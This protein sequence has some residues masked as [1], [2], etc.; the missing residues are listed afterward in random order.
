MITLGNKLKMLREKL[1]LRQDDVAGYLKVNRQAISQYELDKNKP[2][3]ENLSKL[4]KLYNVSEAYLKYEENT[5]GSLLDFRIKQ[6]F[7][8]EELTEE[9]KENLVSKILRIIEIM[10]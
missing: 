3:R 1:G 7:D 6:E 4:A 10:K 8:L 2:N 9:E 5:L